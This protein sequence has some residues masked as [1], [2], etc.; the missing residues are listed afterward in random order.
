VSG[1]RSTGSGRAASCGAFVRASASP[2]AA[3]V[4]GADV[5]LPSDWP[6]TSGLDAGDAQLGHAL[7]WVCQVGADAVLLLNPL[8]EGVFRASLPTLDEE[9]LS[10][11]R[12]TASAAVYLLDRP[13][14]DDPPQ[15]ALELAALGGPIAAASVRTAI[16]AAYG[17]A[18][19]TGRNDPCH[20]GSGR[21][22]KHCHGR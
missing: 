15:V 10:E 9:W 16:D 11:V 7:G 13:L 3:L 18:P 20:C 1:I 6:T 17:R 5:E 4:V 8:G 14:G 2:R 22:F 19:R 21:K 12:A